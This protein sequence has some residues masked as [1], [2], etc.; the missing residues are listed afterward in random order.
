[1]TPRVGAGDNLARSEQIEGGL[2][3]M[4]KQILLLK[5]RPSPIDSAHRAL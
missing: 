5:L 4:M 2:G 1:M 3:L